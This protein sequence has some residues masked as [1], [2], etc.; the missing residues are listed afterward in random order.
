MAS[1]EQS[2]L[3]QITNIHDVEFSTW[4]GW[5]ALMC[6]INRQSWRND[7]FG[8]DKIPSRLVHPATLVETLTEYLG[9]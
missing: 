9:G 7:F 4:Q 2:F 1:F 6:W 3:E 5:Q 8:G